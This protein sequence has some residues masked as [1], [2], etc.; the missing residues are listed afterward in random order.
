MYILGSKI[1]DLRVSHFFFQICDRKRWEKGG[2]A[3]WWRSAEI[4]GRFDLHKGWNYWLILELQGNKPKQKKTWF[5]KPWLQV[6]CHG[7]RY[8][9]FCYH[10]WCLVLPLKISSLWTF[11]APHF[12]FHARHSLRMQWDL[13]GFLVGEW[14]LANVVEHASST[15]DGRNPA[16]PGMYKNPVNDGKFT[17]ST[18]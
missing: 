10:C 18:G 16:P 13:D 7:Q 9:C 5:T 1:I 17:I 14:F 11:I 6:S 15:V 12:F 8:V 2:T 3:A 4:A